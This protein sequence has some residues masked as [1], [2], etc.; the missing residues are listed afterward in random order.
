MY[1]IFKNALKGQKDGKRLKNERKE[2]IPN[3][4]LHRISNACI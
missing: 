1:E 3:N 2:N 4:A